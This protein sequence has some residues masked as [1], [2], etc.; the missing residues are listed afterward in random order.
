MAS[1][2]HDFDEIASV[3][4]A[5]KT[6]TWENPVRGPVGRLN[7]MTVQLM[8]DELKS[9]TGLGGNAAELHA[10]FEAA[11]GTGKRLADATRILVHELF[12]GKILVLDPDDAELK[13]IFRPFIAQEL[14]ANTTF[15]DVSK[16]IHALEEAGYEAQ[17]NPREINLFYLGVNFRE[18]IEKHGDNFQ[19]TGTEISF[20]K[21]QLE[22]ELLKYPERFSPNV[23][24]RPLYQQVIL[25]NVAYVG[26]P[27]ELA[28]WLEYKRMF[29]TCGVFFP[30]LQP[31]HF[32][33]VVDEASSKR[34]AKSG[35]TPD[36]LF[37]PADELVK[38]IVSRNAGDS[39]RLE[40]QKE[41]LRS[42]FTEAVAKSKAIDPT[43]EKS[44]LAEE[45]RAL[46][47]LEVLEK[48]MLRA[49]K[50]KQ[51]IVVGQ[52]QALQAKL[53]PA[54]ALQERHENFIP[55]Y[56]EHGVEFFDRLAE[57]FEFPVKEVLVLK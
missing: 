24:T 50:V 29:E 46:K 14:F 28:Y 36:E 8:L 39:I 21:E 7:V 48:K 25:P 23:V 1:E 16:S 51:E 12:K 4:V 54:G 42:L 57:Q 44:A 13:K 41:K 15:E 27:G 32:A 47:R 17:V 37:M 18:R 11:Y 40:A 10:I 31:R 9:I 35:I 6:L 43:L 34:M 52:L 49:E 38:H 3:N 53:F 20:T 45:H 2:D 19:V 33:L 55:F 22:E 5:G 26:G 30:V 56:L